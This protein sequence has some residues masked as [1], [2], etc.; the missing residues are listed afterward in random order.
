SDG[1]A[2]EHMVDLDT[3]PVAPGAF[4]PDAFEDPDEGTGFSWGISQDSGPDEWPFLVRFDV[5][6]P[7]RE[8]GAR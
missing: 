6:W 8:D 7:Q 1:L 4:R 3:R 2:F 5:R